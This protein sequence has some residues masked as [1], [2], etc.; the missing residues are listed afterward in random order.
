MREAGRALVIF[1]IG[2]LLL[3]G[4]AASRSGVSQNQGRQEQEKLKE[5]R[6][7]ARY[8][9]EGRDEWTTPP[10]GY[11]GHF[12][13][14]VILS[15]DAI[16]AVQEYRGLE[17]SLPAFAQKQKPGFLGDHYDYIVLF[18]LEAPPSGQPSNFYAGLT[19]ARD[20]KD[21]QS[22]SFQDRLKD[23][24]L[25]DPKARL[26]PADVI[27]HALDAA[28]GNYPLA[29][30]TAHNLLKEIA[31]VG[32]E[33]V[34]VINQAQKP[35][36]QSRWPALWF[37]VS[38]W[39]GDFAGKLRGL[40]DSSVADKMGPWYHFFVPL[41]AEAWGSVEAAERM[42][43]VEHGA[44]KWKIFKNPDPEK[45]EIDLIAIHVMKEIR[46]ARS[47]PLESRTG[48]QQPSSPG[49]PGEPAGKLLVQITDPLFP[50]KPLIF[51]TIR[52]STGVEP[53]RHTITFESGR[54]VELRPGKYVVTVDP[55]GDE[56]IDP[57]EAVVESRQ[58]AFLHFILKP[59]FGFIDVAV[60]D[61][62]TGRTLEGVDVA[63]SGPRSTGPLVSPAS[64]YAEPG[65]YRVIVPKSVVK[66]TYY[67]GKEVTA[68]VTAGKR[69]AV[70]MALEPYPPSPKPT[71]IR[72]QPGALELHPGDRIE[73]TA[74]VY[75]QEG[76]S[77]AQAQVTW[78]SSAPA[79]A[80]IDAA[81]EVSGIGR[82]KATITAA[83]GDA[84]AAIVAYVTSSIQLQSCRII[85]K[86]KSLPA[87]GGVYFLKGEAIDTEGGTFDTGIRFSWQSSNNE[88]AS[89]DPETGRV[90]TRIPGTFTVALLAASSDGSEARA[91]ED[92]V[93]ENSWVDVLVSGKVLKP[94][95]SPAGGAQVQVAGGPVVLSG[96]QGRFT[97]LVG[98]GPHPE[99]A[100]IE[101][102]A[103][104]EGADGRAEG[105][106]RDGFVR[107]VTVVLS[108]NRSRP[109]PWQAPSMPQDRRQALIDQLNDW[110][111]TLDC[112][113][114]GKKEYPNSW[115]DCNGNWTLRDRD[116]EIAHF[117]KLIADA[118][119]KLGLPAMHTPGEA[120]SGAPGLR[121]TSASANQ[122]AVDF[123][124]FLRFYGPSIWHT[125]PDRPEIRL[126]E[127]AS[128][129]P[130]SVLR[131]GQDSRVVAL[132]NRTTTATISENTRVRLPTAENR[133]GRKVFG[134]QAGHV[135]F[136]RPEGPPSFE[137]IV[138]TTPHGSLTPFGTV[139][140]V[141][142]DETETRVTVFEGEIH[143]SG[144]YIIKDYGPGVESGKPSPQK[145]MD[146]RAGERVRLMGMASS[147]GTRPEVPRWIKN[148]EG[149]AG[150]ELPDAGRDKQA[151]RPGDALPSW[152]K[153]AG[154]EKSE[155][156]DSPSS[157]PRGTGPL[158]LPDPWNH[159]T[160]Q[161]L[162]DRWVGEAIP[163]SRTPG[164]IMRYNVWAQPLSQAAQATS[165]P[166]H[167]ADWTRFRY[168]W[169][170][171]WRYDSINLCSLGAFIEKSIKGKSLEDCRKGNTAEAP[172]VWPGALAAL[173]EVAER[174]WISG[175]PELRGKE[176]LIYFFPEPVSGA[177]L[178]QRAY[179]C[180]QQ[181]QNRAERIEAS[182]KAFI[183]VAAGESKDGRDPG[184][185]WEILVEGYRFTFPVAVDRSGAVRRASLE[186]GLLN[187]SDSAS[188]VGIVVDPN[189]KVIRRGTCETLFLGL[190]E[191]K[192]R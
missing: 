154:R 5:R 26:E 37:G 60:T 3:P 111:K 63:I 82:G 166:E 73:I 113:L 109:G 137:D 128:P 76:N 136:S 142:V 9:F 38:P 163:P 56:T 71:T 43:A 147:S 21:P 77:I 153:P 92:I 30:L 182:H 84:R 52:A 169:E 7:Q 20:P 35:A 97:T 47:L 95:N 173:A 151:A 131:T 93:V 135:D 28:H 181:A 94:D 53:Q 57:Q 192:K 121:A 184:E 186:N 114:Q 55:W 179:M 49:Q 145:E 127:G 64:F 8:E 74:E 86:P 107:D 58:T 44:R 88:V 126:E 106:I 89:V 143:I 148:E 167:P 170:N 158:G 104:L 11:E 118:R 101:V 161:Q 48:G 146:V 91:L 123:L 133:G 36:D 99:G 62:K 165:E 66:G 188:F 29:M 65:S 164:L 141:E 15:D 61:G 87:R 46:E 33:E 6:L 85:N 176:V 191:S 187:A 18:G 32:R 70:G 122:A 152:A 72:I 83:C 41:A 150:Q 45:R 119:G 183:V 139:Y 34:D 149:A 110:Q 14:L 134:I 120:S 112:L 54:E 69:T 78:S 190:E 23:F 16:R 51:R 96:G 172:F 103:Y 117:Q 171:R 140:R 129:V 155:M 159:P 42:T 138:V 156:P 10:L 174:D 125:P 2:F 130:G 1:L 180:L 90:F 168:L 102:E 50:E 68:E 100:P 105:L 157:G 17:T 80:L 12:D 116:V 178:P 25:R 160:V 27:K 39:L 162:M 31:Y 79:V 108:E 81:G 189:G 175:K 115:L 59:A 40:R 67:R 124:S 19:R 132:I 75:D 177:G 13:R 98:G 4:P 144:A 185:V 24:I 22:R